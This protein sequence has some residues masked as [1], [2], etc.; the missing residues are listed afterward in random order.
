MEARDVMTTPAVT[1]AP[2]MPVDEIARLMVAR[3]ISGVPVVDAAG[4][5]V[6]IVSEGDLVRHAK[7]GTGGKSSWWLAWFGD[8]N[9]LAQEYAKTHGRTA[10]DVMTRKVVTATESTPL[11]RIASL[12]ERN[13]IKR[14]PIVRRGKVVGIVSRANLLRGLV[15]Q[16]APTRA[17]KVKD[18]DIRAFVLK[19]LDAAGIDAAYVN[20][21]VA[22]GNVELWGAVENETQRRALV[23]A[24]KNAKGV[25]RVADNTALLPIS[26]RGGAV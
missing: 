22:D 11:A 20:V 18:R 23:L 24:A 16:K 1:I 25:K 17:V 7:A 3:G 9:D 6:G 26:Y 21:V 10:D 13:R 12:L 4:R 2:D 14:V 15:A 5:A 19:Q 8:R